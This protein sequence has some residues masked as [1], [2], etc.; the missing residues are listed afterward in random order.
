MSDGL[1]L[2]DQFKSQRETFIAQREQANAN[3]QQLIGAIYACELMIQ[4][5]ES[6]KVND[7]EDGLVKLEDC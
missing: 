4:K 6:Q 3:L 5:L 7:V 2:L 1:T